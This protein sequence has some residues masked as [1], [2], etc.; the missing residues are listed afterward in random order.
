MPAYDTKWTPWMKRLNALR[1]T[2]PEAVAEIERRGDEIFNSYSGDE[3]ERQDRLTSRARAME[4]AMQEYERTAGTTDTV[5]F[6]DLPEE[7]PLAGLPE[8][9]P[10]PEPSLETEIIP[11]DERDQYPRVQDIPKRPTTPIAEAAAQD[12]LEDVEPLPL[13]QAGIAEMENPTMLQR[14]GRFAGSDKGLSVLSALARGGQAYMGGRA[15]SEAN[16]QGRES[17]ARANLINALSSRAGARGVTE[18]PK[19]GKLGNLFGTLADIGGGLREE[20]TLERERDLKER[21]FT[22]EEEARGA[23]DQYRQNVLEGQQADRAATADYRGRQLTIAEEGRE[24]QRQLAELKRDE[25]KENREYRRGLDAQ[26]EMQKQAGNF[27]KLA[28]AAAY[29]GMFDTFDEFLEAHPEVRLSYDKM[30]LDNQAVIE[31]QFGIGQ[32]RANKDGA[33]S[34]RREAA[35]AARNLSKLAEASAY[36]GDAATLQELLAGRP[37]FSEIFNEMTAADR[38]LVEALFQTG[39]GK[40]EKEYGSKVSKLDVGELTASIE[41]MKTF[42]D[43]IEDPQSWWAA[44]IVEGDPEKPPSYVTK[45]LFKDETTYT[46]LRNGLALNLASAF[47]RG[48]PT[49]KDYAVALRMLPQIGDPEPMVEAKW[50]ALRYLIDMK[51]QAQMAGWRQDEKKEFLSEIVKFDSRNSPNIDYTEAQRFFRGFVPVTDK[52]GTA[53][54]GQ[55]QG[56]LRNDPTLVRGN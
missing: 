13:D 38:A 27:A 54:P 20:R 47:N 9:T 53:D 10:D 40:R 42:Y 16:K 15:Q 23:T 39:L 34:R 45:F 44:K 28:D 33:S 36:N 5:A 6:A 51:Q 3:I 19:M 55:G 26:S 30:D 43:A 24:Y 25:L 14:L 7:D 48:K 2:N 41:V 31:G 4:Q 56:G 21:K 12:T 29:A 32:N 1:Q 37:E 17:Q 52:T 49:D 50:T 46:D 11:E 22:S 35:D 8:L 18:K